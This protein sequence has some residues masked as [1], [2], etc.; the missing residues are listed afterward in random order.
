MYVNMN[1]GH[2]QE[3]VS[4][5]VVA[6]VDMHW[7]HKAKKTIKPTAEYGVNSGFPSGRTSFLSKLD[8]FGVSLSGSTSRPRLK[9]IPNAGTTFSRAGN[10][11]RMAVVTRQSKPAG[12]KTG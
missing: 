5:R 6:N 2:F 4:R 12:S 3:L 8:I 7:Q 9:M 1:M 11:A 10:A